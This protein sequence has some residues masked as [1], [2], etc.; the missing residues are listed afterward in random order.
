MFTKT[1]V[2]L[3]NQGQQIEQHYDQAAAGVGGGGAGGFLDDSDD[4]GL[5]AEMH[6]IDDDAD[7]GPHNQDDR[8]GGG[9]HQSGFDNLNSSFQQP[10][11]DHFDT[12]PFGVGGEGDRGGG[13][14]LVTQPKVF[15]FT[16]VQ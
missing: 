5:D 7:F 15:K 2:I 3:I 4:D 10:D 13:L 16:Y 9:D 14:K 6:V 8:G 12:K 11:L 1:G